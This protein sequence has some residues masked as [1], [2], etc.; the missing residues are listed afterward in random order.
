MPL[1]NQSV[2]ALDIGGTKVDIAV[3]SDAGEISARARID[4]P[5]TGASLFDAMAVLISDRV[6]KHDITA[7]GVACAGPMTRGGEAV[8]P[9]NIPQ[10]RDFALA[11][12]LRNCAQRPVFIEGDV[13]ALALAEGRF[14]AARDLAHNASLVVSTGVGGAL[15]LDGRLLDGASGNS[16][17]LGHVTVVPNGNEC[18]C[19]ARGCLEAEVS[20]WALRKYLGVAPEDANDDIRRRVATLVGSA[21]GTLAGVLDFTQCFVGGSVALG[22]GAPFFDVATASARAHVGLDFARDVTIQPTG[23]G[24][25]G[26]LLGAA[27]V[28]WRGLS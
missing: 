7:V 21:I 25:D 5:A 19:G 26:S 23:L 13:R 22:Y 14:G 2:L 17:H 1:S 11:A 15:V 28:A 4:V 3:V 27:M 6:A 16:G 10:W 20:G 12:S 8:S 18:S 9:I 24:A